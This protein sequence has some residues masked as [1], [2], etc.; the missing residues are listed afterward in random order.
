MKKERIRQIIAI[1]LATL[2][3][4]GLVH[5]QLSKNHRQAQRLDITGRSSLILA[6]IEHG[7][8]KSFL[9][10][11]DVAH[12]ITITKDCDAAEKGLKRFAGTD[13]G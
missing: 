9:F 8:S 4:T 6:N 7:I 13:T 12:F 2:C 5:W 10:L 3:F 1:T 11:E